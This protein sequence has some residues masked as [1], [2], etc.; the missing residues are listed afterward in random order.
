MSFPAARALQNLRSL[1]FRDHS[2]E[3]HEQFVLRR[4]TAWSAHEQSLDAGAGELLN[5]EN[6][7]RVSSAQAVRRI[8]E[9][10]LNKPLGS[11]ESSFLVSLMTAVCRAS[12]NLA[13]GALATAP[14]VSGAGTGKGLAMRSICVIG[15]GASPSAF[16]AGH[17][18]EELDKRLTSALVQARPAIFLDNYNSKSL[19][20][21]ILASALTENPCEVQPMGQTVMVRLH[22]R[23]FVA[24]T[25][26]AVQIAEDMVS[27]V[28]VTNFDAKVEN[29]ELR[30]FPPGFLNK[31]HEARATL[32]GHALTIWRWG[33]QNPGALTRGKPLRSYD[34]WAEWCRDPLLSLGASDPVDRLSDLK[35]AD[36]KR[37]RILAVFDAWWKAHK[38]ALLAAKDLNQSVLEEIDGKASTNRDGVFKYNKNY[39]T[40]WLQNHTNT[41]VSGYVLTSEDF[42]TGKRPS[43]NYRLTFEC[44]K[45][46][47]RGGE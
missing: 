23:T 39:V 40:W 22:T 3:L 38:D 26:N 14:A 27:R 15:S 13:P 16:T 44:P 42:G 29:P 2:L 7:V 25:G 9:N 24:M 28:V 35:A 33:R 41:R 19:T 8:D 34:V 18:D 20:S 31:V 21:D 46:R 5:Q 37:K 1:V 4:R 45:G 10:G 12:L 43:I 30:P 11:D 17:D 47:E 32:L 6:L 36:P